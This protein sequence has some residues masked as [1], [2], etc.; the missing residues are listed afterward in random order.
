LI[1]IIGSPSSNARGVYCAYTDLGVEAKIVTN[2]LELAHA[3][4]IVLPGVGAFGELSRF[5]FESKLNVSLQELVE[6]GIKVLGICLGMQI[7]GESSEESKE[8]AGLK[9]LNLE[10]RKFNA[11]ESRVPHTGWDQVSIYKNHAILKGL[12][13]EFSAYFSHSYYMPFQDDLSLA[14]TDYGV[15]FT[16]VVAKGNVVGVQFHP[17]RSQGNGRKILSNFADW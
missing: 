13:T 14:V 11:L 15:A 2:P 17:E 5:L 3:K 1:H 6:S 8:T 16:S 12:S 4:K 9:F 10:S 7:L